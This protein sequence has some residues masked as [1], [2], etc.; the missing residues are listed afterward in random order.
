MNK[1]SVQKSG[2]NVVYS[3]YR[4]SARS[5]HID[6]S[7]SKDVF[8]KLITANCVY[9]GK[10]PSN[11]KRG[12][13]YNGLDRINQDVGYEL[14]NVFTC[15][16]VCNKWKGELSLQQFLDHVKAIVDHSVKLA[17]DRE[18]AEGLLNGQC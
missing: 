13:S 8:E 18:Y 7:L 4:C 5:R 2:L 16:Y 14:G 11:L 3:D 6:F 10:P 17:S 15:C 1:L 9:C 12:Y